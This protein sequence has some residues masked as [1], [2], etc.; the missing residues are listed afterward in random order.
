MKAEA[1]AE[2]DLEADLKRRRLRKDIEA[3]EQ[4]ELTPLT[5]H[6]KGGS[7]PHVPPRPTRAKVALFQRSPNDV[8]D[9]EGTDMSIRS[10]TIGTRQSGRS[11]HHTSLA[12]IPGLAPIP[13]GKP[14]LPTKPPTARSISGRTLTRS[15]PTLYALDQ[16]TLGSENEQNRMGTATTG[17]IWVKFGFKTLPRESDSLA[18]FW[19]FPL[20]FC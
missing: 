4:I 3:M 1:D 14:M 15:T 8:P 7:P 10:S 2:A 11:S 19:L 16:Q 5:Q 20:F 13:E 18:K 17:L 6:K 12:A 9:T